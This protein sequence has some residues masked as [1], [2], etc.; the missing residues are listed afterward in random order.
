MPDLSFIGKGSVYIRQSGAAAGLLD[1]GN[2]SELVISHA[3]EEKK[4][5][6]YQNPGGGVANS[7]KR[8]SDV[9]AKITML[10]LSPANLAMAVFGDANAVASGSATAEAHT[11]YAGALVPLDYI[12]SAVTSVTGSGGTPTYVEGTDYEVR[13]GGIFILSGG[14]ITDGTAIEVNYSYGGQDA[15]EALLNSAKEYHLF[16]DGLNEANSGKAATVEVFKLRFGP[17]SDIVVITDDFG[18]IALT[19]TVNKDTT[20]PAGKSQYYRVA[21]AQ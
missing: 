4:Q 2:C 21:L 19:G 20:K 9:T 8:I 13:R 18:N 1:V 15:V 5:S 11:A 12:P 16:F 14:A 17:A 7:I 6:D 3:E 10:E